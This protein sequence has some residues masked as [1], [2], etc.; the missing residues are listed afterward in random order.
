MSK[1]QWRKLSS[2]ISLYFDDRLDELT[3]DKLIHYCQRVYR[4]NGDNECLGRMMAL[5][6][7]QSIEIE[8]LVSVASDDVRCMARGLEMLAAYKPMKP[9]DE[10]KLAAYQSNPKVLVYLR[11]LWLLY[12]N[13]LVTGK[14]FDV[15]RGNLD[16]EGI[17]KLLLEPEMVVGVTSR[18]VNAVFASKYLYKLDRVNDLEEVVKGSFIDSRDLSPELFTHKI[19]GI[20]HYF[21][22]LSKYYSSFIPSYSD[23][24]WADA[25]LCDFERII[26]SQSIDVILEVGVCLLLLEINDED[27]LGL[28]F[29]RLVREVG[30]VGYLRRGEFTDI[31]ML[32]HRNVLALIFLEIYGSK[33]KSFHKFKHA[34]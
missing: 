9:S 25:L 26:S 30:D 13:W 19:Y 16:I 12:D 27:K 28:I 29:S 15:D 33:L 23:H 32:E 5:V 34:E 7:E 31:N 1:Q 20:T 24:L 22:N 11:L 4:V 17:V 10:L 21:I 14:V 8:K 18:V 2:G 6:D 3:R